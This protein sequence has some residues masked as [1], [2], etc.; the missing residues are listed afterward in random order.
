[1]ATNDN[2]LQE[3]QQGEQLLDYLRHNHQHIVDGEEEQKQIII[4][5]LVDTLFGIY[6]CDAREV[7]TVGTITAVP[8]SPDFIVGIISVRGDVESIIDLNRF[9]HLPPERNLQKWRVIIVE[10]REARSGIRVA[11]VEDVMDV[12]VSAIR[13]SLSTLGE[14]IGSFAIGEI[15]YKGKVVTLLDVGRIFSKILAG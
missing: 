2:H 5:R 15:L 1:M 14:N 4:F 11:A 8:G 9:L 3:K 7:L 12:P 13:E 10:T 6:G